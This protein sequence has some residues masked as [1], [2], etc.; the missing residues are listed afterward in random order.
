MSIMG[1]PA[2][3]EKAVSALEGMGLPRLLRMGVAG[4]IPPLWYEIAILHYRGSFHS[5][6]MWIPV[7]SLPLVIAGGAVSALVSDEG[8]SRA[9]FRPFAWLMTLVGVGGTFF[10]LRGI[11]RQ[12]GGF[13]NWKYNVV[14]GPPFPAPP[15]VALLGLLGVVASQPATPSRREGTGF[16]ATPG[17]RRETEV[18][19]QWA[20]GVDA[21]S[22]VLLGVEAGYNHWMGGYFN[23]VMFMPLVLSPALTLAHLGALT[24]LRPA[25][26]AEGPLSM[27]AVVAGLVG[28]GFH[29]RNIRRRS[30]GFN[31]QN[32][33]YGP[34]AVA[35]LQ[36]S[37]QGVL[38]L[39]A[40]LFG[41]KK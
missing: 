23:K 9:V 21:L 41:S 2:V 1:K 3:I 14:T 26:A 17:S 32:L 24:R 39:L 6:Y 16:P 33:F 34:P 18:L 31:W 15:Q 28:F 20:R 4:A 22:Y 10:H 19:A 37:G 13:H 12:M 11:R 35:P 8:R 40:A 25:R 36:L 38:G 7:A 5:R 27:L 30:G 29:L